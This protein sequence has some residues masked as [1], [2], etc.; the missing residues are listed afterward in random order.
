[1]SSM[2]NAFEKYGI[3]ATG[4]GD[5]SQKRCSKCGKPIK[6]PKFDTCYDCSQ[7][8]QGGGTSNLP[9]GYLSGCYFNERGVLHEELVSGMA[10]SVAR[11]FKGLKNNQIRRFYHHVRDAANKLKMTGDWQSVNIDVKKLGAFVAEAKGKDKIPDAFYQ[12]I[13]KNLDCVTNEKSFTQG[14]LE[15]FQAVLAYFTYYNPKD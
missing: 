11:S 3:K 13:V 2:K 1:M 14:F 9:K 15:H 5:L 12:F 6:N 10:D 7:K 8:M 4:G